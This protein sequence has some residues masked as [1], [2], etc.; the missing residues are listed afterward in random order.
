VNALLTLRTIVGLYRAARVPETLLAGAPEL[1]LVTKQLLQWS[2]VAEQA[3]DHNEAAQLIDDAIEGATLLHELSAD[4]CPALVEC[5]VVRS[6]IADRAGRTQ[7]ALQ[8]LFIARDHLPHLP[9]QTRQVVTGVAITNNIARRFKTLGDMESATA[10][11]ADGLRTVVDSDLHATNKDVWL[12]AVAMTRIATSTSRVESGSFIDLH[13]DDILALLAAA[14][15]PPAGDEVAVRTHV[16][17][18]ALVIHHTGL[19]NAGGRDAALH[20]LRHVMA[21]S[22]LPAELRHD[23][24]R[25]GYEILCLC[26]D[27]HQLD[28]A[29]AVYDFLVDLAG[30]HTDPGTFVEQAKAA[31]ELIQAYHQANRRHD[32]VATI[33]Q[34]L[35]VLRTQE[36]LTAR[37]H[38]LGQPATEFLATIDQLLAEQ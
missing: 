14:P 4:A 18:F 8:D 13:T 7:A 30:D 1:T 3:A 29:A 17:G 19:R 23:C 36:Y 6:R 34:A 21:R 9:D 31:T 28:D 22:S 35:P 15:V 11:V 10:T 24:A 25:R 32:V 26:V 37:E 12:G 2:R 33:H 38:D 16:L 20:A 5:L 27:A